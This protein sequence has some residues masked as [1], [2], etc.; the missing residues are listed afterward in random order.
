MKRLYDLRVNSGMLFSIQHADSVH[1]MT[2]LVGFE[3]LL[4]KKSFHIWPA[5][6]YRMGL[7]TDQMPFDQESQA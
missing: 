3:A 6:L 1:A 7:T 5:F 2:S 4:R